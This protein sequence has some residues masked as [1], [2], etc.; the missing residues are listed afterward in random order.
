[1]L[2]KNIYEYDKNFINEIKNNWAILTVGNKEN[3]F[4]SM[5]VSWGGIGELFSL[6]VAFIFVR[7]SRYTYEFSEISDSFTLAFLSDEYKKAKSLFGS[8]S[9]R[10]IDKYASSG[11][12]PTFDPDFNGYY[13]AEASYVFKMKKIYDID[14]PYEKLPEDIKNNCYKNGDMHKMYICQIKQYLVKE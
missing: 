12:H 8:K 10:D 5:T 13:P 6:D 11:L 14:L 7:H 2:K 1:M 9:G 3:G 4:N